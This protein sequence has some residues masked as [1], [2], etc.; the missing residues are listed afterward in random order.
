MDSSVGGITVRIATKDHY[1]GDLKIYKG[2]A[3]SGRLRGV[4]YK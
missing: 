2:M 1:L 3:V 4:H